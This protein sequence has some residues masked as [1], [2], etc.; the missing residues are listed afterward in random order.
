MKGDAVSNESE[1][2]SGG[3][4]LDNVGGDVKLKARGDIVA[5]D[6]ITSVTSPRTITYGFQDQAAKDSFGA[7]MEEL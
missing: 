2:R 4:S 5:H 7:E 1:G 6:K 3:F